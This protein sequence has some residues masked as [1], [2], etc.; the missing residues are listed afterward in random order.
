MKMGELYVVV[1]DDDDI[2]YGILGTMY[3]FY[4][5]WKGSCMFVPHNDAEVLRVVVW[6][7]EIEP[8]FQSFLA[9]MQAVEGLIVYDPDFNEEGE[10][11]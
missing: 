6:G 4:R 5:D 2:P 8:K 11:E 3:E 10:T 1:L 7:T 9:L